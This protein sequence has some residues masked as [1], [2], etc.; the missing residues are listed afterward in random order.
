MFPSLRANETCLGLAFGLVGRFRGFNIANW[1]TSVNFKLSSQFYFHSV[2][3]GEETYFKACASDNGYILM[4][5]FKWINFGLEVKSFMSFC[6]DYIFLVCLIRLVPQLL[7]LFLLW[8]AL[9]N[10][11]AGQ[12]QYWVLFSILWIVFHDVLLC[13][14]LLS[15]IN[16]FWVLILITQEIAREG[17]SAWCCFQLL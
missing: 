8:L 15:M 14:C 6:I 3:I 9:L 4:G 16:Q 1:D 13:F 17:S 2:F 5:I 12:V 10:W 11:S 7:I